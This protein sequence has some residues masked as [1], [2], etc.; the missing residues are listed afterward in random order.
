MNHL[1]LGNRLLQNLVDLII[2]VFVQ[3]SWVRKAGM[4]QQA[5]SLCSVML[6]ASAEWLEGLRLAG[7]LSSYDVGAAHLSLENPRWPPSLA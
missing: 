5:A 3:I 6:G 2:T 7:N 4:V 1:F